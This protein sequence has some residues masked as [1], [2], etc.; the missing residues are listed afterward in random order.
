ME[1]IHQAIKRLF[2][3]LLRGAGLVL[4]LSIMLI[5]PWRWI[6]PPVSAFMLQEFIDT[7]RRPHHKWLPLEKVSAC[8]P[9]SIVAAED[10]KFPLHSGFDFQSIV[11]ALEQNPRR[12][13]GASTISQ[14]V[15]KNLYLWNGRS[16]F[17]KGL[18]A[19]L[20]VGIEAMWPKKRILEIYLNIVEFGPGVYG[21]SEA[22][23]I[24]RK[25]S[26]SRLSSYDCA[27]LTAVLPN[28][29]RMSAAQP[30]RY[31]RKRARE[32]MVQV[33]QLGGSSYLKEL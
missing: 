24:L 5:L 26:A 19:Y 6:A 29:K 17:R 27:L 2:N 33:W 28:P 30:T 8:M 21:I 18:E 20:T 16:L 31:V 32:I 3:I 11:N 22:G 15:V 9:I 13:R 4:I 10:Q 1:L 23:R 7:G 12:P 14:Q 25:R